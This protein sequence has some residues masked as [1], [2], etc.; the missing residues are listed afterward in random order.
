MK[1]IPQTVYTESKDSDF[2]VSKVMIV[3][4]SHR[5][6]YQ[7]DVS[8]KF[9]RYVL[10]EKELIELLTDAFNSGYD[11]GWCMAKENTDND[12]TIYNAEDFVNQTF[13]PQKNNS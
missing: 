1:L 5:S 6:L 3:D 10:S 13:N 7:C 12:D 11:G 4:G 2:I 8:Q 9:N